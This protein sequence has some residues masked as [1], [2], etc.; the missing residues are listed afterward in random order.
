MPP[1][2]TVAFLFTDIEGSTRRW[3]RY[4]EAM[5]DALRR[6]D[7]ILRQAIEAR[8]GFVFKT[9]GD[10][11][12]AAFS[13]AADAL[14]SAVE[15]QRQIGR[16]DFS[17]INGLNV[18]MAINAGE[19]DER[20][21]D[22]FGVAVNRTARLLS[23]GHGGQILLTGV[24]AELASTRLPSGVTLRHLGALPLRD[25]REPER[26][27]QPMGD[28]LRADVAPLR[29]L[30]T[31]PNNLPRLSTSFVGRR[32]DL[33]RVEALLDEGP[34]LTIAGAGGIG[35]TRLALEVAASR[36]NDTRDGVW[37]V[38]LSD[39][40]D[41]RLIPGTILTALGGAPSSDL[42]PLADLLAFLERRELLLVLDNSEH[43]VEEAAPIVARIVERCVHVVVLATSRTPFDI[44]AERVYRLA[45]LDPS[46]AAQLFTERARAANP[47]VALRANNPVV[48]GICERLDGIALAIELAAA[49]MRT[50]S[51]ESLASHLQLRL[52][53]GG[54][55]RRARQQTMRALIDWSYELLTADEQQRLCGISVF[56][57]G[58]DLSGA[59]EVCGLSDEPFRLLDELGSLVD[60]SMLVLEP[61]SR[62]ERY[63]LLEPIR[64]YAHE[65]LAGS[66]ALHEAQARHA[67]A[68]C[69]LAKEWYDEWDRGPSADWFAV[70]E[71][72][73][74]NLRAALRWSISEGSDPSLGSRVVASATIA[75]LRLGLL[76]EGISWC[77]RVLQS[78]PEMP[79]GVEARLRYG[80]SMLYS[81]VGNDKKC[82]DEAL[83]AVSLYRDAGDS[84][85]L[86]RA[87]SQVTSRYAFETRFT[88]ARVAGEESL[89]LARQT[90]DRRLMADCLRRCAEGFASDGS[91]AIRNRFRESVELFRGLG[92]D[93]ETA[94][95]LVWW[96]NW[97]ERSGN[98]AEAA[99]LLEEGAQ[100]HHSEAAAMFSTAEIASAYL[101]IGDR[102]RAEFYARTTLAAAAK[103]GHEILASLA[104]SYL[105]AIAVESDAAKA[106]RLIGNASARL[107]SAGWAFQSPDT[108]TIERL[109][110]TLQARFEQAELERLFREGAAWSDDQAVSH[111]LAA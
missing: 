85:G 68:V 69:A 62:K 72:D 87:L 21:G 29:E 56:L 71:L 84:R 60:K 55:D 95:A 89:D 66:G 42:N 63:R 101:A 107:K 76:N 57:R 64:E 58:F 30:A 106:A 99:H 92:R 75:F 83:D 88:E 49:R 79:R 8:R 15:A 18:R 1:T 28:G 31:P 65:K 74:A 36:V 98:Y 14:E 94:R 54:R 109:H 91:D 19:T 11:F 22:Y 96:G 52:L 61:S 40:G 103:E 81:S 10:A 78:V 2:G 3:E 13:S 50:M 110:A 45:T 111:A 108:T 39:V 17:S 5:R 32:E 33:A 35:K 67:R 70:L 6:H 53:A 38:D 102:S 43:L 77:E 90:G 97:E 27:Y 44:T 47:S 46:S 16:E 51:L 20:G 9:I 12:C 104:L 82:L 34:L 105:A 37:F 7:A 93:D 100:L 4:G 24:A 25:V 73:L 23:A 80:C 41:A 86:A 48:A 59:A 26:V